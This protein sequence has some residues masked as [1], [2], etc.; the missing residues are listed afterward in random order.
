MRSRV[1]RLTLA[2]VIVGAIVV[3]CID[4]ATGRCAG[5]AHLLPFALIVVPLLTGRYVGEQR[6][7]RLAGVRSTTAQPRPTATRVP[8][9]CPQRC[10]P[11][12]GGLIA[13]SL[14]VRPPPHRG[15]LQA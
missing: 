8:S 7:E 15:P 5:L 11:R 9:R 14:A 6:L 4:V 2:V 13:C 3:G 12:G 10:V 1:H